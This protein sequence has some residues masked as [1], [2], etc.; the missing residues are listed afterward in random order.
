LNFAISVFSF[1]VNNR[2]DKVL[3]NYH[4]ILNTP[5]KRTQ[6]L[7]QPKNRTRG[8]HHAVPLEYALPQSRG[9]VLMCSPITPQT[10]P[11]GKPFFSPNR[12]N[13]KYGK[14][15]KSLLFLF[16]LKKRH[17]FATVFLGT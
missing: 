7:E 9:T 3:Q 2:L 16:V 13:K 6:N 8:V 5:R 17:T 4:F 12:H 14:A 1:F 15:K 10:M 11:K